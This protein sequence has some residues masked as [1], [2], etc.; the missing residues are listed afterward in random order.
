M[1]K[2]TN[3]NYR[4]WKTRLELLFQYNKVWENSP[5]DVLALYKWQDK[6]LY[7]KMEILMHVSDGIGKTLWKLETAH[8]MW[9]HLGNVYEPTNDAQQAHTLQVPMNYI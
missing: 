8:K 5:T 1:E 6:D 7:A 4:I 3:T 2:L 9:E